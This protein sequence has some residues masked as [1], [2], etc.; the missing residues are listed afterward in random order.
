MKNV[1]EEE[2]SSIVEHDFWGKIVP[3]WVYFG[4]GEE[5]KLTT[6]PSEKV[7]Y[8]HNQAIKNGLNETILLILCLSSNEWNDSTGMIPVSPHGELAPTIKFLFRIRPKILCSCL[9]SCHRVIRRFRRIILVYVC[10]CHLAIRES[11]HQRTSR[12]PPSEVT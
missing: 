11:C 3:Y 5:F 7:Q 12:S 4:Q 8:S 10:L 1:F 6:E 2:K 9:H